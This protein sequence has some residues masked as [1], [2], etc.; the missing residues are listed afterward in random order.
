VLTHIREVSD[1]S[2][3][4]AEAIEE[5]SATLASVDEATR[6]IDDTVGIQRESTAHSEAT[7]TA[8][9]ERLVAIVGD[10]ADAVSQ[11]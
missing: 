7:L 6:R 1:H 5:T 11:V 9:I 4:V 10:H 2:A 3:T 8:A